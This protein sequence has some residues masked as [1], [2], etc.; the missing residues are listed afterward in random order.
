M[1]GKA[2]HHVTLATFENVWRSVREVKS[3]VCDIKEQTLRYTASSDPSPSIQTFKSHKYYTAALL[4]MHFVTDIKKWCCIIHLADIHFDLFIW[5]LNL[6]L[7]RK[8]T[9]HNC[10]T[11]LRKHSFS[12]TDRGYLRYMLLCKAFKFH[13]GHE[14]SVK[15][16]VS[17]IDEPRRSSPDF[18]APPALQCFLQCVS[19]FWLYTAGC[20]W[21]KS[22][23]AGLIQ[24]RL[25]SYISPQLSTASRSPHQE[26]ELA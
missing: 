1:K 7:D 19:S 9:R 18:W 4:W 11:I 20:K 23:H 6:C 13:T 25:I 3:T 15:G 5:K 17:C 26:M 12:S 10:T 24:S 21:P 22:V 14:S 16:V 8:R 2:W